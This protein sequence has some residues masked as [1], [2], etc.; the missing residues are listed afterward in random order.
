MRIVW[1][2]NPLETRVELDEADKQLLHAKLRIEH[3]QDQ[4]F[5]AHRELTSERKAT[6]SF[7]KRVA[8][9]VQAL[10]VDFMFDDKE[11]NGKTFSQWLDER[12]TDYTQELLGKHMG[13][14]TC[15]PSSCSKCYAESLLGINTIKGLGKHSTYK[16]DGVFAGDVSIDEA[17]QRLEVYQPTYNQSSTRPKADWEQHV[18]RWIEEAKRAH[19]WLVAYRDEHFPKVNP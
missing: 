13:D 3:L 1:A 15:V 6:E 7:G 5:T 2:K 16:I 19:A 4:L 10:D 17:I 8:A 11:R 12:V 14:C 18:P 9:A